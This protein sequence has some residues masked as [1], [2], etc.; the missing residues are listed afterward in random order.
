VRELA[1]RDATIA[2]FVQE[3]TETLDR[4]AAFTR[5]RDSAQEERDAALAA[6]AVLRQEGEAIVAERD[7]QREQRDTL[8]RELDASRDEHAAFRREREEFTRQRTEFEARVASTRVFL[9]Q[10][11]G[12]TA[13]ALPLQIAPPQPTGQPR[14]LLAICGPSAA[15]PSS[16]Q[17]SPAP[18]GSPPSDRRRQTGDMIK[19]EE[20]EPSPQSTP[21]AQSASPGPYLLPDWMA[22]VPAHYR[23]QIPLPLSTT[24]IDYRA[25]SLRFTRKWLGSAEQIAGNHEGVNVRYVYCPSCLSV[26]LNC[27]EWQLKRRGSASPITMW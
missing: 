23:N 17:V 13:D 10:T 21:P 27:A 15:S 6:A 14:Q 12:G 26:I 24:Q 8:Q 9:Q 1:E 25:S 5:E 2:M 20:V 18:A 4:L 11:W 16:P 7:A 22:A 3:N 19:P